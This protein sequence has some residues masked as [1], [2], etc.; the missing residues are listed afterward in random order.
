MGRALIAALVILAGC[1]LSEYREISHYGPIA[2]ADASV[3]LD[4]AVIALEDTMPVED[5]PTDAIADATDPSM[6]MPDAM[7]DAMENS[8]SPPDGGDGG[9]G[10]VGAV[11]AL[12]P[13]TPQPPGHPVG[14]SH[15]DTIQSFYACSTG[16]GASAVPLLLAI[17]A[18]RR[19]AYRGSR[20]A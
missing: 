2:I 7:P 5:G 1:D 9:D 17:L 12:G 14:G 10:G 3:A 11:D 8:N 20:V 4:D 15:D 13:D 16:D 19:R 18:L 6:T